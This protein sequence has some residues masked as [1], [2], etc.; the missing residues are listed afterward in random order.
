M[1]VIFLCGGYATRL[2]PLTKNKPKALLDIAGKPI[3]SHILEK[4]KHVY[5][6][7]EIVVSTN[8]KF[9]HDFHAWAN[10]TNTKIPISIITEP[11]MN[12]EEKFG[13]IA[14]INYVIEKKRI[15]DDCMIIAGD[16]MFGFYMQD[17]IEFFRTKNEPVV[18]AFDIK[19]LAKSR[20]Y[21]ILSIDTKSK[22]IAFEEKPAKPASTLAS[23]CCYIFPKKTIKLLQKYILE[24]NPKDAPGN[25]LKWLIAKDVVYAFVFDQYWFDIG[26]FGSL[27]E[28]RKFMSQLDPI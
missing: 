7:D 22:I 5:E 1:K 3:L 10:T 18:A 11:T 23:T 25:F 15:D 9:E 19:D 20:L 21:G 12:E 16:N 27:E 8:K 28:T 26:D 14:G 17:F 4:M 6:I 24:G 13:A 2:W